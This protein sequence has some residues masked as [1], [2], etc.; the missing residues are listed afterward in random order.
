MEKT[1]YD[2]VKEDIYDI[3]ENDVSLCLSEIIYKDTHFQ[4]L[5]QIFKVKNV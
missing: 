5:D 2:R 3:I 1:V 4:P